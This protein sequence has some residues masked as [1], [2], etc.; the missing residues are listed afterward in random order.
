MDPRGVMRSAI[1]ATGRASVAAAR[2]GARW[3]AVAAMRTWRWYRG[4]STR[5]QVIIGVI[6]GLLLLGAIGS[7]ADDEPRQQASPDSEISTPTPTRTPKPSRTPT[8]TATPKATPTVTATPTQAPS[9]TSAAAAAPPTTP[10]APAGSPGAPSGFP[11]ACI[12]SRQPEDATLVRVIDGDTIDVTIGSTTARVRYIGVDTPERGDLFYSE[13]TEANRRLLGDGRL[14]LYRDVS[15][16]DRYDRLLRFVVASDGIFVNLALV[17]QGFAQVATF[18]PD[19]ACAETFLSA[20][21]EAREAGQGLWGSGSAA[22]AP[23]P[24]PASPPPPPPSQPTPT[25]PPPPPPQ[26]R[27]LTIVS[28]TSPVKAGATARL[29]AQ[30]WAGAGCTITYITPSGRT[31]TAQGLIPKTAGP[32]GAVSWSWTIGS[33]TSPGT[34]SVTVAC[35]GITATAPITIVN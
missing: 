15:E 20:Q 24:T 29:T 14:K 13:A 11:A 28:L 31:S 30:A 8:A 32:D 22:P 12:P 33:N 18:P 10:G 21:R 2:A 5:A 9:P 16:R 35:D 25:P 34:G 17:Q 6:V 3:S 7:A 27:Q 23:Q 19:V 4:R 26:P 1:R